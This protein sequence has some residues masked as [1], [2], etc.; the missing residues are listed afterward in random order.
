MSDQPQECC[1]NCRF[2]SHDNMFCHRYP[3]QAIYDLDSKVV[4]WISSPVLPG[5]WCGEWQ[6]IPKKEGVSVSSSVCTD[7][8]GHTSHDYIVFNGRY[9]CRRCRAVLKGE[10]D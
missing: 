2:L 6:A 3:R 10:G 8:E 9:F 1:G 5:S 4:N 7:G